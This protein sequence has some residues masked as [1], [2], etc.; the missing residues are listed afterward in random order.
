MS[1]LDDWKSGQTTIPKNEVE[2]FRFFA[3]LLSKHYK[4]VY[5]YEVHG[6]PGHVSFS[7]SLWPKKSPIKKELGDLIIITYDYNRMC[8]RYTINQN[9][10]QRIIGKPTSLAFI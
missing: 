6:N 9:K 1:F 8:A 2:L 7:S 3:K 5:Y 10:F 4:E